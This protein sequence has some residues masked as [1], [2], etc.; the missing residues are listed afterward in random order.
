MSLS[1]LLGLPSAFHIGK[2]KSIKNLPR[3]RRWLIRTV[4]FKCKWG[5]DYSFEHMGIFTDLDV[6]EH[7]A[8]VLR[9][10]NPDDIYSVKEL[11]INAV[12]PD[13][14]VK[15][16]MYSVPA[17]DIND[18]YQKRPGWLPAVSTQDVE[19]WAALEVK[20]DELEACLNGKCEPVAKAV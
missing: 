13:A 18:K 6:A 14:P 9:N 11:P 19:K 20:F 5:S 7:V 12:L 15:Y 8:E 3:W 10:D 2:R 17:S 1:P 16:G 4:Y